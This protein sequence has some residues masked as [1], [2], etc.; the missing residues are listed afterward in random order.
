MH[1]ILIILGG[2]RC[3]PV[4]I[5]T[6]ILWTRTSIGLSRRRLNILTGGQKSTGVI[7]PVS[8]RIQMW[9]SYNLAVVVA[10]SSAKNMTLTAK[11]TFY[12]GVV[13]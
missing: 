5:N 8:K 13:M 12:G 1:N 2:K 10:I 9:I 11:N 3:L 6:C 7:K 4:K